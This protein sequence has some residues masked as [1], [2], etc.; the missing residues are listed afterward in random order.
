M[1][2]ILV[3]AAVLVVGCKDKQD[4]EKKPPTATV[5]PPP[6]VDWGACDAAVSAAA[7][8]PLAQRPTLLIGGCRVC[9]DWTPILQ[10]NAPT[11]NG[12][13]TREAIERAMTEC[14]AF[15][16]GDAKLKF[17]GTLDN[18]RGRTARTPWKQLAAVC[19]ERVSAVPDDRFV[20]GAYFALDRIG[21]RLGEHGGP[22]ATTLARIDLPL[23]AVS[24]TGQGPTLAVA[25]S[26]TNVVG[27]LHITVL[28][29][30]ITVGPLPRGRL[31]LE[32]VKVDLG[33]DAYPGKTVTAADLEK[34]LIAL[35]SEKSTIV[36]LLA[37]SGTPVKHLVPIVAAA[38]KVAT[39]RLGVRAPSSLPGWE[40]PG[41]IP[42]ALEA[43]G[44][45][46]IRVTESMTVTELTVVL[47]QRVAA[48]AERVGI[49]GP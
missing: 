45:D 23:P 6:T 28:G 5:A 8:A 3:V 46:V 44:P 49:S 47:D 2:H 25:T 34:A 43:G 19:R 7:N 22:S 26:A 31:G 30:T 15:C 38:A 10:W 14:N 35:G 42:V 20:D 27:T 12:G 18:A 32:G 40:L 4:T 48:K 17:L 29:P 16:V 21:R 37:P 33:S 9:G 11:A 1:R 24:V 41:T 36:T 39:V 13:P